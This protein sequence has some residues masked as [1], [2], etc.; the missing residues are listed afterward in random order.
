MHWVLLSIFSY[1]FFLNS[2][3]TKVEEIIAEDNYIAVTF[4]IPVDTHF[5]SGFEIF[6]KLTGN[7]YGVKIILGTNITILVYAL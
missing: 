7:W 4:S 6:P 1:N 3:P 2:T 5:N